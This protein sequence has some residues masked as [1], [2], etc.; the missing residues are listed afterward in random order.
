VRTAR[1]WP[2]GKGGW[3]TRP[4]QSR[5]SSNADAYRQ[6]L[7]LLSYGVVLANTAIMLSKFGRLCT[8]TTRLMLETRPHVCNILLESHWLFGEEIA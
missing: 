4:A 8:T 7:R 1:S 6:N 3:Y 2:D 5:T